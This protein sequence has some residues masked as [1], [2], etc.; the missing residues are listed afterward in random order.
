MSGHQIDISLAMQSNR[1]LYIIIF[2]LR[3][4][5][6]P[7]I[8]SKEGP[9]KYLNIVSHPGYELTKERNSSCLGLLAYLKFRKNVAESDKIH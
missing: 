1:K 9:R 3:G 4:R 8:E 5:I 2:K 6:L 7:Y